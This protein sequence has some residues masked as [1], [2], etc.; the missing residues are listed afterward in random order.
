MGTA[1]E[2]RTGRF[3]GIS[4]STRS[5][6]SLLHLLFLVALALRAAGP[7]AAAEEETVRLG[8]NLAI[9]NAGM[10]LAVEKG[11]FKEQG[12]RIELTTFAS[13]VKMVQ[14]MAAD[15]LDVIPGTASAGLFN[16]IAQ[17]A[18][19]R[20]VADKGQARA[21]TGYILLAVRKDLLDSGQVKSVRDLKG[22]K[23]ADYAKGG[24]LSYLLGKMAEEAGLSLKDLDVTYLGAPSQLTAFE[25]K[26]IDAAVLAEPWGANFEERGLAVRFRTPDQVKGLGPVQGAGIIYSGKFR[27]ERRPV[28]QRWMNAYLKG[29]AQF[30]AKGVKDPE[31]AAAIERYTK[32]PAK[33][34]AAAFPHYQAP[35]GKLNLESLADQIKWYVANGY[36][37]Q[38]ISVDKVVDLSFLQ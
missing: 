16:A 12:I 21:G 20:I 6:R 38:E 11:Y 33:V 25:T 13:A 3:L 35:D 32:V 23:V 26:A 29:A 22:R 14:A 2:S 37:P 5:G 15:E 36:M 34:V 10:Y 19:Y 18:P 30:N 28:A 8:D 7:A 31:V 27:I 4:P 24:I 17:G 9:S 1:G